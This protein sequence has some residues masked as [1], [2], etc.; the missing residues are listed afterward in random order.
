MKPHVVP[1]GHALRG[2]GPQYLLWLPPGGK[3]EIDLSNEVGLLEVSTVDQQSGELRWHR[4]GI[5]GGGIALLPK[6]DENIGAVY[7]LRRIKS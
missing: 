3:A 5:A 2:E 7:W 6:L 4:E 1:A